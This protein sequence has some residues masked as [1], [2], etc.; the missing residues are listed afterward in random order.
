MSGRKRKGG[1]GKRGGGH[2][3]P[4]ARAVIFEDAEHAQ[5]ELR[6]IIIGHSQR[7]RLLLVS[8]TERSETIHTISAR[9]ATRQ[10][11]QDYE[12][13]ALT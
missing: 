7:N 12:E 10:E 5:D 4:D 2:R 6:E 13:N 11:R 1:S 3:F 9:V 8:F